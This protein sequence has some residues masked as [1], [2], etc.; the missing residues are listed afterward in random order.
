MQE[1]EPSRTA[2]TAAAPRALESRK[3]VD[4]RICYDP[5]AEKFLKPSFT[6]L[7]ETR[8]PKFLA[9]WM[10]EQMLPGF[11]GFTV[12]RARHIDEIVQTCVEN[13]LEQLVILGAGYDSRAYRFEQLKEQARVFEVDHPATQQIKA[14]KLQ[15]ILGSLPNHVV[16]VPIDFTQ[17]TLSEQLFESGYEKE[18]NTLFVWE[19][20]TYYM[21]PEAVDVTLAF[22]VNNS[23]KGS[24]IVFDYT[25]PSV[26]EGVCA[27]R[28]AKMFLRG[29]DSF[30]EPLC[31]GIAE[32]TIESFLMQ[33][34]FGQVNNV[35]DEWL[36]QHYFTGVN[37]K[38]TITP[39]FEIVHAIVQ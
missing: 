12:A 33:R 21:M 17:Q 23:G 10:Y 30:G 6:L 4:Q 2:G 7:G 15:E 38:R 35:T 26:V 19:G 22:V 39:I 34:G 20:V 8:V 13:G 32:G 18:R 25:H 24:S 1:H 14:T 37:R 11:F 5:F 9:N 28:E 16:F 27:R 3:P 29:A 36:K 31:F